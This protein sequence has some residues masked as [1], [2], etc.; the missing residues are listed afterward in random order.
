MRVLFCCLALVV[1]QVC[2]ATE[3][4]T[5][6]KGNALLLGGTV[7]VDGV[8]K[9]NDCQVGGS[10]DTSIPTKRP[11]AATLAIGRDATLSRGDGIM[12]HLGVAQGSTI[13]LNGGSL[14]EICW[15]DVWGDFE[16]YGNL[17]F[18]NAHIHPGARLNFSSGALRW[19][20]APVVAS[21]VPT[22]DVAGDWVIG[23]RTGKVTLTFEQNPYVL[24]KIQDT[25]TLRGAF[26]W[27]TEM[28][29]NLMDGKVIADGF[30]IDQDLDLRKWVIAPGARNRA[31]RSPFNFGGWDEAGYGWIAVD[32]GRLLLPSAVPETDGSAHPGQPGA[33]HPTLV[34]AVRVVA[35]SKPVATAILA[36]DR[37]ELRD[38]PLTVI[39][40]WQLGGA[41]G[42]ALELRYDDVRLRSLA[43]DPLRLAAF[44]KG[45]NG[46][47]E[48]TDHVIPADMTVLT[49]PLP[50]DGLVVV[51]LARHETLN[52]TKADARVRYTDPGPGD[53]EFHG[54]FA[55]W[56]DVKNFGAKGDGKADDTK[57]I[58]KAIDA[59]ALD[60]NKA[61]VYLPKGTYRITQTL[62]LP[63]PDA[64]KADQGF[65]N[66]VFIGED[67]A[68]TT[69]VWDGDAQPYSPDLAADSP[70]QAPANL[71]PVAMLRVADAHS[72]SFGRLTLDGRGRVAGLRVERDGRLYSSYGR[73]HDMYFTDCTVGFWNSDLALPESDMDS[74]YSL[75]RLH[76]TRCDIG[77]AIIPGNG[78]DYWI[79]EGLFT[80][81]RIGVYSKYGDF[82]VSNSVFRRSREADMVVNGQRA[83]GV[84][85]NV[86]VGSRRFFLGGGTMLLENNRILDPIEDD[87][88]QL[89]H[90]WGMV[91]LDNQIRSR[92]GAV[93]PVIRELDPLPTADDKH[94]DNRAM[95]AIGNRFTV[96][97]GIR[98]L[99]SKTF[100]HDNRQ[101]SVEESTVELP[102]AAPPCVKRK[103]F[104]IADAK[105]LQSAVDQAVAVA[106][107]K[108]DSR[109]VVHFG[110]FNANKAEIL[111]TVVVPANLRLSIEGDGAMTRILPPGDRETGRDP[112]IRLL[113]PSRVSISDLV[114]VNFTARG[115]APM[116]EVTNADQKDGRIVGDNLMT[117]VVVQGLGHTRVWLTEYLYGGVEV[118]G[119]AV[120]GPAFT[121]VLSGA[122]SGDVTMV[123][124][125][126]GG[127]V[128]A[129][130][131]WSEQSGH[132][133]HPWALA[134]GAGVQ[135]GEMS[136]ESMFLFQDN[137]PDMPFIVADGFA[138]RVNIIGVSNSGS[139]AVRG[140]ATQT[141]WLD[142]RGESPIVEGKPGRLG[143]FDLRGPSAPINP[144]WL[145]EQLAFIR[146]VHWA[147]VRSATPDGTTDLRLERVSNLIPQNGAILIRP[148]P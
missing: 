18:R 57:A 110:D 33:P 131:V 107:L 122:G 116:I 123:H 92:A 17:G 65:A 36:P 66:K 47:E 81:C 76:F 30:G 129:T 40:A 39:N 109:P 83:G 128:F 34:G 43:G 55:G 35:A 100:L 96:A 78:Y 119:P 85:D 106:T 25:G 27:P 41:S 63:G 51:G 144:A 138:G 38:C 137:G 117:P 11:V 145:D 29:L 77:A 26:I 125:R 16:G 15:L 44:T 7:T 48:I 23:S 134:E 105:D 59:V 6:E 111:K 143:R 84:R 20:G 74:E 2:L 21:V 42:S 135:P 52:W 5:D 46:W 67:P 90:A 118:V 49:K 73:V 102:T 89:Y 95:I 54:P 72:S 56:A 99:S 147:P 32:R 82:R 62:L 4:N 9:V 121:A 141:S 86:S 69:L 28:N 114:L 1:S 97:N 94:D 140:D 101:T 24:M 75:L 61:V 112:A 50:A 108:P 103:T 87:A 126:N 124:V 113:G 22:L 64:V 139:A 104:E 132:P 71:R 127:R 115:G 91:F 93:G 58:Q 70:S 68:T 31:D 45:T 37:D 53:A 13:R 8:I 133:T 60:A 120:P 98:F 3:F 146:S 10:K 80:D 142:L 136:L 79:R 12:E 88:I 130:D 148:A 14:P 19:G